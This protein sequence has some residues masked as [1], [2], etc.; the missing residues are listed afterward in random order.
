[1]RA[2][3]AQSF[4]T[5]LGPCLADDSSFAL[6][7][8]MLNPWV[9]VTRFVPPDTVFSLRN[10][11]VSEMDLF[12]SETERYRYGD[13]ISRV[14]QLEWENYELQRSIIDSSLD[15]S[16]EN[17][18]SFWKESAA[19]LT[20]LARVCQAY[21]SVPVA[22]SKSESTFSYSG[23][24]CS[25]RRGQVSVQLAEATTIAYDYSQQP[26]YSFEKLLAGL[27]VLSEEYEELKA[28][29]R[30]EKSMQVQR[31]QLEL[32]KLAGDGSD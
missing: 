31:L 19:S 14:L 13:S 26:G 24:V 1:M 11:L 30:K 5:F 6:R 15:G 27:K 4:K 20:H 9:D 2:A 18:R 32:Q 10:T 23:D 17:L 7:A 28:E 3:F 21:W 22:S 8:A 25:R 16:L 12:V 29:Q